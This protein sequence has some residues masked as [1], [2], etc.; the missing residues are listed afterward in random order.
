MPGIGSSGSATLL[1]TAN[2][3]RVKNR[4]SISIIP[5]ILQC[6]RKGMSK[7]RITVGLSV[8]RPEMIAIMES[9]MRQ[10]DS[11]FLEEPPDPGFEPMLSGALSVDEYL[12][13]IDIEYPIFS[14]KMCHLLRRLKGDGKEIFQIEPYM[15]TLIGIHEFFSEG[16]GPYDLDRTSLHYPVY[17]AE[18]N[19]T[20][21]LV[22]FY[23]A[24][25]TGAFDETL[26]AVKR[27]ARLD[28]ARFRLRDSLRLQAL[29]PMMKEKPYAFIEAGAI[30]YALWSGLRRRTSS[31]KGLRLVFLSDTALRSV[32]LRGRLYGPGDQLTLLY[33]F[34]RNLKQP[35]RESLLADRSLIYSK[36]I[37]KEELIGETGELPHL[38]DKMSC[39]NIVRRLS[40]EDCRRLF[41]QIYRSGMAQAH[42][43]VLDYLHD[44]NPAFDRQRFVTRQKDP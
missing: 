29:V 38:R 35:E 1:V 26:D 44:G 19:A 41:P 43:I 27:F 32:G 10:H 2:R 7:Q 16:H 15:E 17:L 36:L 30:H 40:L 4:S 14:R 11:V 3:I 23:Q 33:V 12:G 8:H 24:A 37:F 25:M 5:V 18:R 13:Q 21:A 34:H 9:C 6:Y 20:G 31:R 28:A 42:E 22:A 39:I